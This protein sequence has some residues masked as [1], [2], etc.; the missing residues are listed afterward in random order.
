MGAMLRTL[1]RSAVPRLVLGRSVVAATNAAAAASSLILRCNVPAAAAAWRNFA[2]TGDNVT[3]DVVANVE[4][5]VI[6][7]PEQD[8]AQKRGFDLK[9]KEM[10]VSG[11]KITLLPRQIA[12][13]SLTEAY[14]QMAMSEKRIAKT[15][16]KQL[17]ESAWYVAGRCFTKW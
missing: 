4:D 14:T 15:R 3:S 8:P 13:L 6:A 2:T 1:G 11:K 10:P 5:D 16:L 12:G 7:E 9:A 17:M